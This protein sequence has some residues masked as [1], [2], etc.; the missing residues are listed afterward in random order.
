MQPCA[1]LDLRAWQRQVAVW[2]EPASLQA[3][4]LRSGTDTERIAIDWLSKG[5]KRWRPL[6]S[7]CVHQA[8]RPSAAPAIPA[9]L[10]KLAV[11]VEC[12]HKASLVH[13]DIEDEDASRYGEPTLHCQH[14]VA[15]AL[16]VGDLLIGEG[17]R[18]IA[19]SGA[20]AE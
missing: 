4:L 12:F 6:L 1:S 20:S 15:V 18:L 16:N 5:G 9:P 2:F 10:I 19:A 8:L 7:L 14:G 11:A 17:Y 3:L 13:D